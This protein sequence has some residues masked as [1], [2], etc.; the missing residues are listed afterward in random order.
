MT[1][2]TKNFGT[3]DIAE[4]KLLTFPEGIIGFPFLKKFALIFD[5]ER[6]EKGDIMWLQSMEEG[7]FAMPV[8]SPTILVPTY[9]PEVNNDLLEPLGDMSDEDIFMLV[10]ITVPKEIEKMSVNLKAPFVINSRLNK[11]VQVA[12]EGDYSVKFPV[13]NLLKEN[14]EAK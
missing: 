13:Y 4:D 10:T 5:K 9:A 14:R 7:A 8:I 3:V 2:E 6:P 1:F 11:G 12:C